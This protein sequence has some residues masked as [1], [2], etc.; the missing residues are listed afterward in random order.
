MVFHILQNNTVKILQQCQ[1]KNLAFIELLTKKY[2]V[3]ITYKFK[4]S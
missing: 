2:L 1:N 4:Y 3:K